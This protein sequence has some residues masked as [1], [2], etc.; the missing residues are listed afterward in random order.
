MPLLADRGL[1]LGDLLRSPDD[2]D[3]RLP[4]VPL[5]LLRGE[6]SVLAPDDGFE[7]R[8]D[9]Q[10]LLAGRPVA[11]R[12][13]DKTLMVDSVPAYLVT[14]RQVPSGWFWRRITGYRPTAQR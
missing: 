12:A 9:D 1:R 14:G 13:L 3:Q 4:A 10:L 8:A 5:L 7:L 11:R 2:R 6:E